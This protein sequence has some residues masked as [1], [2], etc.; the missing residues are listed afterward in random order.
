[1]KIL[2]DENIPRRL[3]FDFGDAME[4]HTVPEMNWQ[5]KK[6]GDLLGLSVFKGFD[7]FITLDKNLQHQQ[8]LKGFTIH[9]VILDVP[10][11]RYQTVQHLITKIRALLSEP[12]SQQINIVS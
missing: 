1:M 2:L 6:N 5:G 4:V 3:K 8:N 7:C 12:L 11:S 10:D 9:I